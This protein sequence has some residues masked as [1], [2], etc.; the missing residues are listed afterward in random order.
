MKTDKDLEKEENRYLTTEQYMYR[1]I[2]DLC[3][4]YLK[5]DQI[6]GKSRDRTKNRMIAR[7]LANIFESIRSFVKEEEKFPKHIKNPPLQEWS[8]R[9][10]K[11][12]DLYVLA[13]R[14]AKDYIL[15]VYREIRRQQSKKKRDL[16]AIS[17]MFKE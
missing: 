5:V 1:R 17:E 11:E 14:Y 16:N 15:S 7:Q 3:L 8:I 12:P 4:N 13:P 6:L 2:A 9:D 10:T